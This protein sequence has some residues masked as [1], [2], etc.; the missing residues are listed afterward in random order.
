VIAVSATG[1]TDLSGF[2]DGPAITLRART[3]W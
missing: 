1:A 2:V 3:V